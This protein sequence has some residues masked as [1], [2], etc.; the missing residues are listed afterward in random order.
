MMPYTVA[1]K[2]IPLQENEVF[3]KAS[4][5]LGDMVH[6]AT[7]N[8]EFTEQFYHSNPLS[9]FYSEPFYT[10][11]TK[12]NAAGEFSCIVLQ[13]L[14]FSIATG[15]ENVTQKPKTEI[16]LGCM[17]EPAS[18]RNAVARFNRENS[19]YIITLIDYWSADSKTLS[20]NINILY[21]E[22]LAGK[23]PDIIELNPEYVDYL[24]LGEKGALKDLTPYLA[25]S[26]VVSPDALV[27]SV[28][29]A[30]LTEDKLFI[31]PTNFE[32]HNLITKSS[33][34]ESQTPW[35]ME[36]ITEILDKNINLENNFVSKEQL[37]WYCTTYSLD[38]EKLRKDL[39]SEMQMI[40]QYLQLAN[41]MPENTTYNPS[42]SARQ[43]GNLLF[44]ECSI[45]DTLTYMTKKSI[46]GSDS[47]FTGY[48]GAAGNG[49][50]FFPHN[51]FGI[52]A[53][54]HY[55]DVAWQFVENYF[56]DSGQEEIAPNWNFS[57]LKTTLEK[58]LE[59][60]M[61]IETYINE[62][63]YETEIPIFSYLWD[64]EQ[65]YRDVY[66]PRE[67]DIQEIRNMIYGAKKIRQNG[68]LLLT[69]IKEEAIY[70]FAGQ[71][72]LDEVINRITN[73][74]QLLLKE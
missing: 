2:E 48:P 32:L 19:D 54:S 31:L 5:Y 68:Q 24:M 30:L 13:N 15:K 6:S 57:I 51:S 61:G 73:R 67:K 47:I 22:I 74:M 56:T 66:A 18:I 33:R 29:N 62:N 9:D 20:D 28:Y 72:T 59:S 8:Q 44:E 35:T 55:Q 34:A 43:E 17:N 46:W 50:V 69:I 16:V 41:R 11:N 25:N 45:S 7:K 70:Y 10:I 52:N 26:P 3:K 23:G 63:G 49:M 14:S 65:T 4:A 53:A 36:Q 42:Y 71:K 58:Q 60:S 37:L 12:N 38:V 21:R 40:R 27:D 39:E 64:D 1:T